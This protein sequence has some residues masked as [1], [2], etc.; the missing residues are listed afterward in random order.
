MEDE[1]RLFTK[2]SRAPAQSLCCILTTPKATLGYSCQEARQR[3]TVEVTP[4]VPPNEIGH[5]VA[6]EQEGHKYL[7]LPCLCII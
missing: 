6:N 7:P 4:K 3:G 2:Q 1:E 5:V